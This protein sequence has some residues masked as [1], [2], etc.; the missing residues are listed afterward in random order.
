[1]N[2]GWSEVEQLAMA[3]IYPDKVYETY[4][5]FYRLSLNYM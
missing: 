4:F 5:I 1:M 2:G 3:F